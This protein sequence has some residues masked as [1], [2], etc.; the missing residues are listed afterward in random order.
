LNAII[1]SLSAEGGGVIYINRVKG[2][3]SIYLR[4]VNLK[5]GIQL[6]VS[7][8][9]TFQPWYGADPPHNV[10]MIHAGRTGNVRDIAVTNLDEA[11]TD[12]SSFF[13]VIFPRN[14][15]R[16]VKFIDFTAANNFKV[17]GIRFYDTYTVFCNLE[18]NLSPSQSRKEGDL[19]A[20]GVVKNI[21]STG[22]HGGYGIVQI[23]AGKKILFRNLDCEGG[24]A[25]R[26]ETGIPMRIKEKDATVDHIVGRNIKSKNGRS[27]L[28]LS[29]HRIEQGRVDV[30][31]IT[32]LNSLYAVVLENG[33]YDRKGDV[34]NLGTYSS[35]SYIGGFKKVVGGYGAQ[36]PKKYW[37]L[38]PCDEQRSLKKNFANSP[39][40][41]SSVWRSIALIDYRSHPD[42]G[43]NAGDMPQGCYTV[44][45]VLPGSDLVSGSFVADGYVVYENQKQYRDCD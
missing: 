1:D 2:K 29:P 34:E 45:L 7:P 15:C 35:D 40:H 8:D 16:R 32:T 18:C 6:K 14:K 28:M 38:Y 36:V 11:S 5:S 26:I 19:P 17:A 4:D 30:S 39:D 22:N 44:N 9:V 20:K 33:F 12:T 37:P 27:A 21:F 23:R 24:V 3:E 10:F 25:L 31:G 41:E 13:K 42:H 43:C